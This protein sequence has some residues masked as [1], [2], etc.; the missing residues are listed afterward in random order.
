VFLPLT[1]AKPLSLAGPERASSSLRGSETILV[2]EDEDAIRNLIEA[3]LSNQGYRVITAANGAEA[4]D[5]ARENT[6]AIDL[7]ITDVVMPRLSG[8]EMVQ[9][10]KADRPD[11]KVI[12]MSGY[13]QQGSLSAIEEEEAEVLEKPFS[14]QTILTLVRKVLDRG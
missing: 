8:P 12:F 7:V 1:S 6:G 5:L 4:L 11:A 9:R 14:P 2:T 13:A 10:M 3:V